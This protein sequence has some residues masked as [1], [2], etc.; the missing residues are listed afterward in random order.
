MG[1]IVA[2]RSVVGTLDEAGAII[3]HRGNFRNDP[4]DSVAQAQIINKF[5]GGVIEKAWADRG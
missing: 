2:A 5:F 4:G 1:Q 3:R